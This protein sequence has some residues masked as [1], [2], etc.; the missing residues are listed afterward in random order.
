MQTYAQDIEKLLKEGN[1]IQLKPQ[2]YSMYPVLIPGRDSVIVSP[3]EEGQKLKRGQVVLYR[4]YKENGEKDILVLHRIWKV[5]EQGIY[6]VGDNQKEVEGPLQFHQ[7]LGIA[8]TIYRKGKE[9]ST[10]NGMYRLFTGIWL[11]LRPVRPVISKVVAGCKKM[12][13]NNEK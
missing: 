11:L 13:K 7:M 6:L 9:I 4:R 12:L 10:E 5:K 2:G 3:I 1:S 8:I